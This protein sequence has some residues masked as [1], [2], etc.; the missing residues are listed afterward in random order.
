[1]K[2]FRENPSEEI[3]Q[4]NRCIN[5]LVG[6]LA[7]PADWSGNDPPHIVGTLLDTLLGLLQLNFI[8]VRM[9]NPTGGPPVEMARVAHLRDVPTQPQQI[10]KLIRETFGFDPEKWTLSAR[11]TI[12]CGD[13]AIVPL[14]LGPKGKIG[15]LVAGA[16][17]TDFPDQTEMLLLNFAANQAAM[18][19]QLAWL[20]SEQKRLAHELDQQVAQR[21]RELGATNKVLKAEIA[22]RKRAQEALRASEINLRMI[23]DSIPGLAYTLDAAGQVMHLN[24]QV[25]EYFGKT[26]EE[27][28]T[29]VFT[30]AVHPDDLPRVVTSLGSSIQSGE[31]YEIEH[32]CRRADGV[33]RW[34]QVRALPVRDGEDGI[35][36]WYVLLI[37]IDDRKRAEDTIRGSEQNLNQ[38][39][40]TIPALA[41]SAHPDGSAEFFN[42][43]YLDYVGFAAEQAKDWGW[44]AA[45]H[46]DDLSG[47]AAAWQRIM[48]SELPGEAEARLRRH[49]GEFRWFLFRTNP[50]RNQTGRIVKWYG[51]NT[52]ID[53]RKRAEEELLR[54]E[55]LLA[56]G[57]RLSLTGTFYW[58]VTSGEM[59]WSEQ[60][61]R[62]FEFDLGI[63]VTLNLIRSRVHPDD[64][65]L[66]NDKIGKAQGTCSDFELDHRLLMAD[67]S[68]KH[69]HLI[70]RA[71]KDVNDRLEYIG[72]AQDVT[73]SR[74]SEEALSKT[75]SDLAHVTRVT[76]LGVLTASIAHEVKQPLAAIVTNG[77]SSLRWL[78]ESN[79]DLGNVRDLTNNMIADARRAS[80]IV[81]RIRAMT[82]RR[83]PERI[84]LS[85]ND[86]VEEAIVFVRHELHAKGIS[87]SVQLAPMLPHVKGDRV[88]LQ[89]VFV[90]LAI[91]AMQAVVQSAA[92]R[93]SVSFRTM[94]LN[95]AVA[96]CTVEDSGPGIDPSHLPQLFDSFFT[97]KAAGMG[98]GLAISRSIIEAHGGH[99]C[100]DNNSV[101][102]GAR[103]CISLPTM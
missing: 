70:A 93:R 24:Q 62:I 44:T 30:D 99:I 63:P 64:I 90:N 80:E 61:Y 78:A 46:P 59:T 66:F 15:M 16:I 89:Q 77:Q 6:I 97:T 73:Q 88:Q 37:D 40:N 23:I 86:I 2:M 39:I 43:H 22:E 92:V 56:E 47:L 14:R 38:I 55:T 8:L 68:I 83:T 27:L 95:S 100:A 10:S 57:Q 81:G 17:R 35:T 101:L 31:P 41:W 98:L 20:L 75:R 79:P 28:R 76:T 25:L 60:L 72:A 48:V 45:V 58:R 96:C 42:Q 12:G 94:L 33:Y 54:N 26:A 3:A 21:T 5:D 91:N 53:D 49:D 18:G 71:S 69:I 9:N 65:P 4:L 85:L 34:F 7:S 51:I 13:I 36:G 19:L 29:W 67:R 82:T 50:L 102:G 74:L 11:H 84:G 103:F 87:V 32:R 52:D 1:M